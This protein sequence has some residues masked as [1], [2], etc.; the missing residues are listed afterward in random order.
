M[1]QLG[2]E[3]LDEQVCLDGVAE[4]VVEVGREAEA[5]GTLL[6]QSVGKYRHEPAAAHHAHVE[7]LVKCLW[8]TEAARVAQSQVDVLRRVEAHVDAGAEDEAVDEVVLVEPSAQ[9]EAPLRGLP[10][11]LEEEAADVCLLLQPVVIAL[12]DVGQ[13]VGV[14]LRA[15]RQ[16]GGHEEQTGEGVDVLRAED[17]VQVVCRAVRLGCRLDVVGRALA[18]AAVVALAGRC[19]EGEVGVHAVLSV[20][21]EEVVCQSASVDVVLC[22]LGDVRL[23]G[24]Q[25][26]GVTSAAEVTDAVVLQR[27]FR[28]RTD[29]QEAVQSQRLRA[30]HR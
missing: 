1:G 18:D 20:G 27:E 22:L 28:G 16:V 10:F 15:Q 25:V 7:V 8:G 9:E 17:V 12:D 13:P 6:A 23:V 19:L 4:A 21:G 14:V 24:R 30:E 5:V 11:V 29:A 3:A 26:E 2:V